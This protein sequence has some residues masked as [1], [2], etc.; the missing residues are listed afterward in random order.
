MAL[1]AWLVERVG[2]DI[3]PPTLEEAVATNAVKIRSTS[4][5]RTVQ[6][7]QAMMQGLYGVRDVDAT[8]G[9]SASSP[10]LRIEVRDRMDESMFPNPGM[11]CKRQIELMKSL[12][13]DEVV[14]A[15]E[16]AAWGRQTLAAVRDRVHARNVD[17]RRRQR[18]EALRELRAI[19]EG[20]VD[21][22]VTS[23]GESLRVNSTAGESTVGEQAEPVPTSAAKGELPPHLER[24]PRQPSCTSVWEPLQARAN[25]G[26]ELPENVTGADVALIRRAAE[27]RYIN[28]ATNAEGAGLTGGR[29]LRELANEAAAFAANESPT[30]LSVYSGHDSTIIALLAVLGAFQGEWPPV[31]STAA[32]MSPEVIAPSG[33]VPTIVVRSRPCSC[34]NARTAGVARMPSRVVARETGPRASGWGRS[35]G[36]SPTTVPGSLL[37]SAAKSTSG[38]P[39]ATISPGSP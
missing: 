9:S 27:V 2:I 13:G 36:S 20:G 38:A 14:R 25:H 15:A 24:D 34:A 6:S 4:T 8:P 18:E 37:P 1:R 23:A 5:R 31:A 17:K 22:I 33:P 29:L 35:S 26:L 30:K 28:R 21:P 32:R 39:T 19:K 11:S 16:Q 7:A 3:L 12:D 10:A